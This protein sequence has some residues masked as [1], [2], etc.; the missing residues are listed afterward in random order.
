MFRS[1][2]KTGNLTARKFERRQIEDKCSALTV[3]N[4]TRPGLNTITVYFLYHKG[5]VAWRRRNSACR[6]DFGF[7]EVAL[8]VWA[9]KT[10]DWFVMSLCEQSVQQNFSVGRKFVRCRVNAA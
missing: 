4:V 8:C 6:R 7:A 10:S 5:V 9:D 3:K 2:G 1:Y